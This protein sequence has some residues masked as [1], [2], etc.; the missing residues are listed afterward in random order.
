MTTF[1]QMLAAAKQGNL[2][3]LLAAAK[4]AD[5]RGTFQD[6]QFDPGTWSDNG[7]WAEVENA[8]MDGD[9]TDEQYAQLC[10]ALPRVK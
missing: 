9:L 5:T 3:P 1:E 10:A 7:L 2:E 6:H 4:T 8:H